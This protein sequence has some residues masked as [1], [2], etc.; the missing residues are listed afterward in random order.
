MGERPQSSRGGGFMVRGESAP[1]RK[2]TLAL[3]R[4]RHG[5]D[6]LEL[7][8]CGRM[9]AAPWIFG[10]ETAKSYDESRANGPRHS[11]TPDL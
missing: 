11:P 5:G 1:N 9:I 4:F 2:R 10:M 6:R 7:Y 8:F 3:V